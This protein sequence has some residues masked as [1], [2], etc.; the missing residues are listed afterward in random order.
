MDYR[1]FNEKYYIRLDKDD[2]IIASLTEVCARENI[3]AAQINGIG[4]CVM[5]AQSA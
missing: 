5:I 3:T 4:G 2:E 1:K